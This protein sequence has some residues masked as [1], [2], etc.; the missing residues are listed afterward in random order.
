MVQF[1]KTLKITK[2]RPNYS[3]K[4]PKRIF[5]FS[6]SQKKVGEI[7]NFVKRDSSGNKL[8]FTAKVIADYEENIVTG[9]ISD[10]FKK[11]FNRKIAQYITR[12]N[13]LKVGITS[14]NPKIRFEEHLKDKD[15]ERMVVLYKTTS[16]LNVKTLERFLIDNYFDYL[17]NEVGGG[18]GDL[19]N[20]GL[21]FL[22]IITT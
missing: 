19:S 21:C 22:Y 1:Y 15:W 10:D 14:R 16:V 7:V 17:T 12:A 8:L 18:G 9:R 5:P 11:L 4:D 20:G 2:K 6:N 13:E 3:G